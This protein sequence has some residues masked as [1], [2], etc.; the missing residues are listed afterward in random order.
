MHFLLLNSKNLIICIKI[1]YI[2]KKYI[3]SISTIYMEILSMS[4]IFQKYIYLKY[5]KTDFMKTGLFQDFKGI[6]LYY[7]FSLLQIKVINLFKLLT[8]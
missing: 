8:I 1:N 7:F 2:I 3:P 5:F 6:I 4:K